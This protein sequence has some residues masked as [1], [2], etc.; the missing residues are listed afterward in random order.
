MSF[1]AYL[2]TIEDKTGLPPRQL[3]K[4]AHDKGLDGPD[5][6]AGVVVA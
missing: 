2:G 5:A 3:V 1:Q 6:K 4:I